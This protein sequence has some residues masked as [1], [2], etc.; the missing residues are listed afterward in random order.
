[1]RDGL[2]ERLVAPFV[3]GRGTPPDT[4]TRHL[5]YRKL[6]K[7]FDAAPNK[8]PSFKELLLAANANSVGQATAHAAGSVLQ[9]A[10]ATTGGL[11]LMGQLST[12]QHAGALSQL[13]RKAMTSMGT[14]AAGTGVAAST[15][16]L[17]LGVARLGSGPIGWTLIALELSYQVIRT[18]NEKNTE[19]RKVTD[20][21][22]RSIWGTGIHQ[23]GIF[24]NEVLSPFTS[25]EEIIGFYY[26]FMKPHIETDTAVLRTIGSLTIPVWGA[27]NRANHG[28]QLPADARTVTVAFPGW[29]PQVS[30]YTITQ[31]NE[32]KFTGIQKTLDDPDLVKVRDGVGYISHPTDTLGGNI[33]V[34]YWPNAF[35]EPN[36]VLEMEKT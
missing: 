18:W 36:Q 24:S 15:A 25:E 14:R 35:A 17:A 23:N 13:S 11:H 7:V 8:R 1:M 19:E 22:A 2:L 12:Q 4:A 34:K 28:S 32:F 26:F 31:H 10:A 3:A 5:P 33:E 27:V 16:R 29:Q 20:W 9:A 30:A 21:I 6:L